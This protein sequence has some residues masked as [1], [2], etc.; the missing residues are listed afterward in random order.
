MKVRL[1]ILL[2]WLWFLCLLCGVL[3]FAAMAMGSQ[4]EAMQDKPTLY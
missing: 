4:L 1:T 3:S 2:A